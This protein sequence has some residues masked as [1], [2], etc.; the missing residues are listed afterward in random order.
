MFRFL[1]AF[2]RRYQAESRGFLATTDA[3]VS[4]LLWVIG[5][6]AVL[7]LL[8]T[9]QIGERTYQ[10]DRGAVDKLDAVKRQIITLSANGY[11]RIVPPL[12]VNG[13][14]N[15]SGSW[16]RELD[17][18]VREADNSDHYVAF[19]FTGS[20]I[21]QYRYT[22]LAANGTHTGVAA[23]GE[24]VPAT[25]FQ[26][27][28]EAATSVAG[29]ALNPYAAFMTALF[30]KAGMTP[31]AV[32]VNFGKPLTIGQNDVVFVH[33]ANG[34]VGDDFSVSPATL[35]TSDLTLT[36]GNYQPTPPPTPTVSQP[37]G[38]VYHWPTDPSGA[39][40]FQVSETDYHDAFFAEGLGCTNV[41]VP[42]PDYIVGISPT[43]YP[44]TMWGQ[45]GPWVY[46]NPNP[47]APPG[48]ASGPAT[49]GLTAEN[50]GY[51]LI[52]IYDVYA[53][54]SAGAEVYQSLQVMGPLTLASGS[55]TFATPAAPGQ[56]QTA[57][58]TY[59]NDAVTLSISGC[60]GIASASGNTQTV[61]G[62]INSTPSTTS[63]SVQPSG[64]GTCTMT[65]V[66]Q[67]GESQGFTVTVGA[68]PTPTPSPT[69][70][71]SPA[72]MCP[73]GY[74][75][76]YPDCSFLNPSTPTPTATPAYTQVDREQDETAVP[77]QCGNL[78]EA[79]GSQFT[80]AC[81]SGWGD[82]FTVTL[83]G[84]GTYEF[85]GNLSVTDFAGQ[86]ITADY[87]SYDDPG[88]A[89]GNCE[90][91]QELPVS[92]GSVSGALYPFVFG[93]SETVCGY[94][95]WIGTQNWIHAGD[96]TDW[97]LEDE[98]WTDFP[99]TSVIL[100]TL[101]SGVQIQSN[102]FSMNAQQMTWDVIVVVPVGGTYEYGADF[103]CLL[104]GGLDAQGGN[105]DGSTGLGC[106][107]DSSGRSDRGIGLPP[108]PTDLWGAQ[109][110]VRELF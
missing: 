72:P 6:G 93:S 55:L 39:A 110:G 101:P 91:Q 86:T 106:G 27:R 45:S 82:S 83:P 42:V 90:T 36:V 65:V 87:G 94:N 89:A 97:F 38:I 57:S 78:S 51:C 4:A 23:V 22:A 40:S 14:T 50:P 98:A 18:Y 25:S 35:V 52:G 62:G 17:L 59:D 26:V 46:P 104:N 7:L 88:D 49:F 74:T 31:N 66:D 103:G 12:D 24:P 48:Q 53:D 67:Y 30:S 60:S 79:G 2:H 21:Q 69:V 10:S 70:T 13:N 85:F 80:Q 28:D 64:A 54:R 100:S 11:A 8:S 76:T 20:T 9:A 44:S 34:T 75:G 95:F 56:M 105:P 96:G 84:A 32:Q 58:K 68:A 107:W 99:T 29:D 37:A 61:P 108:F 19:D 15:C 33:M 3:G 92:E 5:M 43:Y 71:P 73:P 102:T 47:T 41:G 63:F 1:R 81:N 109:Y 16:C 77:I